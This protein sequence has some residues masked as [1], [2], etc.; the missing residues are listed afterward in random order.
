M[1]GREYH[2]SLLP[3]VN[4][5]LPDIVLWSFKSADWA[6]DDAFVAAHNAAVRISACATVNGYDVLSLAR[7]ALKTI[8]KLANTTA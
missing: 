4:S 2:F 5:G 6:C 3:E 1:R 8:E 7:D